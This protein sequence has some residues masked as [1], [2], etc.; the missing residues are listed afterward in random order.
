MRTTRTM[1]TMAVPRVV[2]DLVRRQLEAAGYDHAIQPSRE[3]EAEAERLDM[4]G[5]GLVAEDGPRLV[6]MEADGL[7]VRFLRWRDIQDKGDACRVCQG[8]GVRAYSSTATWRG[9]IGGQAITGDVCDACWGSGD[10]WRPGADLRKL[11]D[12]EGDRVAKSAVDA[13]ARAAGATFSTAA[14]Q[15][16]AIVKLLRDAVAAADSGR[17]RKAREAGHDS[18]WFAPLAKS[19]ADILERALVA[20]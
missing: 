2:Y 4:H 18:I 8:A 5:I 12:E 10:R 20:R 9:G 14:P 17:S 7:E 3:G 16:R 19:L 15:V 1:A 13:L 6:L 11:R